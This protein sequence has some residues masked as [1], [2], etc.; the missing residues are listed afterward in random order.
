MIKDLEPYDFNESLERISVVLNSPIQKGDLE[1]TIPSE[2]MMSTLRQ[3]KMACTVL[4]IRTFIDQSTIEN[5]NNF[6]TMRILEAY[7]SE[8]FALLRGCP[9][10]KDLAMMNGTII[11]VF[12]TPLRNNILSVV[13]TMSRIHTLRMVIEKK[14]V[15]PSGTIKVRQGMHFGPCE[16]FYVGTSINPQPSI[17]WGGQAIEKVLKLL[18]IPSENASLMVATTTLYG[19]LTEDYKRFFHV[20]SWNDQ[21]IYFANMYNIKMNDWLK[22]H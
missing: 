9:R 10:C 1:L 19:N 16:A 8:I 17:L 7:I 15:L 21:A 13:D 2:E 5:G 6:D 12:E 22:E 20:N 18:E 14:A 3:R 11:G 4:S